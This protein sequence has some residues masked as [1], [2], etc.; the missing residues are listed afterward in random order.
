M[1]AGASLCLYHGAAPYTPTPQHAH[2]LLAQCPKMQQIR[3]TTTLCLIDHVATQVAKVVASMD[4]DGDGEIALVEFEAALPAELKARLQA[5][6]S[7]K[8]SIAAL[9]GQWAKPVLPPGSHR[10]GSIK[11]DALKHT[12]TRIAQPETV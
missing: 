7:K 10:L 5:G 6:H 2:T 12:H 4:K 9:A 3:T 11:N 1:A 8:Q